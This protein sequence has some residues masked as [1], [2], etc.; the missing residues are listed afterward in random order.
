MTEGAKNLLF[1]H[2]SV[3]FAWTGIRAS[4]RFGD[5]VV[6]ML[7]T[8]SRVQTLDAQ[9]L[10]GF[11]RHIDIRDV[12]IWHTTNLVYNREK[13]VHNHFREFISLLVPTHIL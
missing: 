10:K 9:S 7:P 4:A 12:H 5:V 2:D 3:N 6:R 1:V 11:K 13:Y 8:H